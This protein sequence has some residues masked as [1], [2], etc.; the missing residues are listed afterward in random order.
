MAFKI[1]FTR[2][3][4]EK[5]KKRAAFASSLISRKK[6]TSLAE[7]LKNNEIPL[8]REEYLG[9]CATTGIK[10]FVIVSII[11]TTGLLFLGTNKFWLYGV[12]FGLMISL[13]TFGL[14]QAY[15]F[16]YQTRRQ[17]N[18]ERNLIPALEDMMVQL[19]A[20]VPLFSILVNISSSEYGE[21]SSEFKKAVKKMNAG[22]PQTEALDD[23]GR[24]NPSVYFRRTLWQISNGMKAGSDI[25]IVIRESMKSLN[26]EQVL[27]IQ[28]YGNKLNPLIMFYML[29]SVILPALAVTFLTILASMVNLDKATT[30]GLFIGVFVF[31]VIIQVM[32]LGVIKSTRPSLL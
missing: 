16:I 1:P 5:L 18:I 7:I 3:P 26:Q 30:Q 24:N 9:I 22:V 32:F 13:F 31:I 21:L 4:L 23:L 2:G 14:Q 10:N 11:A 17:K 6:E 15:P 25:V 8:T 19:N 12:G 27:Q 20:G 29:I 28:T